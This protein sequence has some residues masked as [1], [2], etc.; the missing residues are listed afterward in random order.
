MKSVDVRG[1]RIMKKDKK[2]ELRKMKHSDLMKVYNDLQNQ[3]NKI[4]IELRRGLNCRV[5][6]AGD[7]NNKQN[8]QIK[9]NLKNIRH[10]I[11]Y[12]NMLLMQKSDK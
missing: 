5:S 8:M 11:A 1:V 3:K 10:S 6:Y 9:G 4:E 7:P 2:D 12:V